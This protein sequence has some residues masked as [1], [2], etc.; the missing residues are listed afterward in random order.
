MEDGRMGGWRRR[1]EGRRGWVNRGEGKGKGG[2]GRG[3]EEDQLCGI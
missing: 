3:K 2:K 1:G